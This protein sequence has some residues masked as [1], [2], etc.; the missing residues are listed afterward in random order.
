MELM[1]RK[2]EK[3]DGEVPKLSSDEI[4]KLYDELKKGWV[5]LDNKYLTISFHFVDYRHTMGFVCKVADIAEAEG[6]HPALHVY[7]GRVDIEI[8]SYEIDGLSENDFILAAKIEDC[9]V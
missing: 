5:I 8:W 3:S 9:I 1:E 4:N 2:C 6:H 7:Y